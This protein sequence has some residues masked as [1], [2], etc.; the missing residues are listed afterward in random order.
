[1]RLGDAGESYETGYHLTP[2]LLD[3]LLT[4]DYQGMLNN[5]PYKNTEDPNLPMSV[6]GTVRLLCI[7][8]ID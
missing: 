5:M 1:M 8:G 2:Y 7:N 3:K 6:K 4:T